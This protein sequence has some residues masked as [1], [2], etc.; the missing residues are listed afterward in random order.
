MKIKIIIKV[1]TYYTLYNIQND[2]CEI[3]WNVAITQRKNALS[4]IIHPMKEVLCQ[5]PK[6][7]EKNHIDYDNND[8]TNRYKWE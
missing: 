7:H 6:A 2:L 3:K 5:Y 4:N 8:N 1:I